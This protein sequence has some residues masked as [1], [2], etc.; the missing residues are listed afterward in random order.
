MIGQTT[1]KACR[2]LDNRRRGHEATPCCRR[3]SRASA[4]ATTLDNTCFRCRSRQGDRHANGENTRNRWT[5]TASSINARRRAATNI[6]AANIKLY[7]VRVI[8]RDATLLKGCATKPT[9]Y[10][11]VQHADQLNSAFSSIA[12]MR[13]ESW[14]RRGLV[15]RS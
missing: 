11:D 3:P 4:S 14:S 13:I 15:M 8:D 7:T 6:K 10:S 9:M 2:K 5:S 1:S 12:Q